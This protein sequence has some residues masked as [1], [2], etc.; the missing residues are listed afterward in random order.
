[1][2]RAISHVLFVGSLYDYGSA[3]RGRSYEYY[4]LY[5]SL[6]QVVPRVTSFDFVE[7]AGTLG[8]DGMNRQLVETVTRDRPDL[9]L[10]VPY[11]NEL[12][13][14]AVDAVTAMTTTVGYFFDDPWRVEY[15]RVWA[16]H[17]TVVT[18][19]DVNGRRK[20]RDAGHTN[21]VFSPFACNARMF[22]KTGAPL[23]HDV[24]FVG[25]FHPARAW[26]L[27]ELRRAGIAVRS[28]GHGWPGGRIS[29]DQMVAIFNETRINLNL[30]NT[31]CWDARYL[32]SVRR[33]IGETLRA[34]RG[35]WNARRQPDSKTREQVKGRHFE[36]N[37]CGG[38]QLT[39]YVEGLERCYEV[40][41]EIA[42][43]ADPDD[44]IDK[45]R[46]Y[47]AHDDERQAV[48][49]RGYERTVRDHTMEQRFR[50]LFRELPA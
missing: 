6:E 16:P 20:F 10:V 21:V 13:F 5:Q 37:A 48:A 7:L 22:H 1:V 40:G 50:A 35:I 33:P 45:V 43:F 41:E 26:L 9:V 2:S 42:V 25:Q 49:A 31:I 17:F 8:R 23:K 36:I 11:L 47:L 18:T 38:F 19:S 32:W 29:E 30:S 27:R 3:A 4:N 28:W 44:L 15:S 14:D 24:S 39:Y 46:Y 34:W 12:S